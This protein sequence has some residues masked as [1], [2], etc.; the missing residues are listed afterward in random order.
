MEAHYHDADP[1]RWYLNVF[2][3][4]LNEVPD[5]V[6]MELQ[7][8]PGFPEWFRDRKK[9]LRA[10]PLINFLSQSRNIVVHKKMLVPKSRGFIGITELRGLKLGLGMPINPLEDSDAAIQRYLIV[11]RDRGDPIDILMPN[12]DSLP[13]VVREWRLGDFDEELIDLCARA[14]LR[15]SETLRDALT[16]LGA[17]PPLGPW[18]AAATIKP[19]ASRR[20][21]AR[22]WLR[23]WKGIR[24]LVTADQWP[25]RIVGTALHAAYPKCDR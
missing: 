15:T 20:I 10:V 16:W 19:F 6:S 7:N 3:K 17:D 23:G 24:A 14:W 25:R 8:E 1:F 4:A 5:L 18:A 11:T 12:E 9:Q 21:A 2:L 13:C 22:S